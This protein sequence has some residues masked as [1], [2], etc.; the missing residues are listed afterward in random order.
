MIEQGSI[1]SGANYLHK[2]HPSVIAALK[3]LE[4]ELGFELFNRSGYRSILTDEGKVFYQQC[5]Q[6]V[7]EVDS[8]ESL[9]DHLK[10]DLETEISIAIGDITP[11]P[12]V[13]KLLRTFTENN[14]YTHLNLLFEN[15]EG[16]NERLLDEEASIIIHPI[17]KSDIRYEYHD[18]CAVKIIPVV[19]KGYLNIPITSD[20]RYEYLR[21]HTQC[22]IRSTA[23]NIDSQ[24][25][26]IVENST[27]IRV[28]DQQTKRE[29][30][31]QKMAWGHMP[32]FL[33]EDDLK[34][35]KLVS[36]E[37]K[38]IKSSTKDIVVSRLQKKNHGTMAILLW[39]S[40]VNARF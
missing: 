18:F 7:N 8:L 10:K 38:Y 29:I 32:H 2:T 27:Y 24:D 21:K 37:G 23:K 17:D 34:S 13:L 19:A 30:I 31:L 1:Q 26:F 33:I 22:I 4:G 39:D 15:L 6:V 35:G 20:L 36:L 11:L 3:K 40:L 14:K 9:A 16:A 12:A 25:H 5:K 28:G